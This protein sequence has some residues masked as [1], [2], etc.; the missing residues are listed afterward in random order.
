VTRALAAVA[1]AI[2]LAVTGTAC[3]SSS[4]NAGDAEIA[5]RT[6]RVVATT[7]FIA[8]L[9][10]EVGGDRV[11]VTGLMGPGVD[12][13]LYKASAGDVITLREA[14]IIFYGGLELEGRMS[15]LFEQL[16]ATRPT[17]AVTRDIPRAELRRPSEYEGRYDPHVWFDIPLWQIAVQTTADALAELDPLNADGYRS[18]ADAYVAD[19]AG[20]DELVRE[21]VAEIPEDRRV[22]VTSH[23]AFAYLGAEYGIEVVGIQGTSTATEAT[24]ADIERVAA[25]VAERDLPAIFV[26]SSVSPQTIE[27]VR[28]A[29]RRRGH[30]V[31]IGGELYG[32]AA[33][34]AGTDAGTYIGMVRH[35]IETIHAGLT[36]GAP[37]RA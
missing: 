14:D 20:L 26:E 22:L 28:A 23:D 13:H 3:V 36:R 17:V 34:D 27:A 4:G 19:L 24:T 6:V 33:G 18:R 11:E 25:V 7:N 30:D 31:R 5:E 32:D 16:E 37:A 10:A 1:V 29:A 21:R 9:V 8:D 12:P 2:V 15:D 35:N